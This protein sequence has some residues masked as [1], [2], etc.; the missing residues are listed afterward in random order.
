MRNV[1]VGQTPAINDGHPVVV[2][3]FDVH[4]YMT[5]LNDVRALLKLNEVP[6]SERYHW[7]ILYAFGTM[8]MQGPSESPYPQNIYY[9]VAMESSLMCVGIRLQSL[10]VGQLT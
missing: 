8:A 6:R 10:R 7:P 9:Y 2:K 3:M 4:D 5:F 1:L